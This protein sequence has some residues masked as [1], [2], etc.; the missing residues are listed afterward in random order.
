MRLLKKINQKLLFGL[1]TLV[2]KKRLRLV[3]K[4]KIKKVWILYTTFKA[5]LHG[6]ARRMESKGLS[7]H[8]IKISRQLLSILKAVI[9]H[10]QA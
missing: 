5:K 7:D 3:S 9:M 4:E 10:K 8:A 2:L 6:L 1:I